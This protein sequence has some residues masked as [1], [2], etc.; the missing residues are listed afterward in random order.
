MFGRA[1]LGSDCEW[2][3]LEA[4]AN[5][6]ALLQLAT[7]AGSCYLFRLDKLKGV[8]PKEV[9]EV[10]QNKAVLKVGVG[11]LDDASKLLKDYCISMMGC[12][13]LRSFASRYQLTEAR[14]LKALAE[15]L[16]NIKLDKSVHLRCSNWEADELTE[17]QINYAAFD[18]FAA[19]EV[20]GAL[21]EKKLLK[22]PPCKEDLEKAAHGVFWTFV[23]SSTQGLVDAQFKERSKIQSPRSFEK[24]NN[25][26][27]M[28]SRGI[29]KNPKLYK[30]MK[31]YSTRQQPLYDNCRLQAPDGQLLS[32]CDRKKAVWYME[33]NLAE[34]ISD[35]PFT[36]R[37]FFEPSG[38][39]DNDR[40]YYLYEKANQ[41]VVCGAT[42]SFVRKNIIPHEYRKHFALAM[43]DHTSH[44]ILLLCLPC[45]QQSN[46]YDCLFRRQLADE[47]HAPQGSVQAIRLYE[48]PKRRAVRSAGRALEKAGN[49]IPAERRAE[50]EKVVLDF[51]E[52]D[53]IHEDLIKRASSLETRVENEAYIPHGEKVVKLIYKE[54]GSK[55]L[56]DF[57]R[58]WREHFLQTMK[59]AHLP[60]L[61]S[62]DHNH[63]KVMRNI[64][65]ME[66]ELQRRMNI[67]NTPAGR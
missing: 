13:D 30:P 51:F 34:L 10:L 53:E 20:F 50:L 29:P 61:W 37:L 46:Y 28:G 67:K 15:E 14:G 55:G 23:K 7:C 62:I 45:H 17:A 26:S 21:I 31:S 18:A 65:K 24:A 48:D 39:P 12:I 63:E 56:L 6:V 27:V 3:S 52:E 44:D 64:N 9:L 1:I 38:R 19:L 58:R 36:V 35:N 47:Y 22:N 16:I 33:K 57:E 43:K 8:L 4:K 42:E 66:E 59:P 11:C 40:D 60:T 2:T 41:C 5:P 54:K 32:T 49:K 25:N